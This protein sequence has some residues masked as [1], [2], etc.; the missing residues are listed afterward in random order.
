MAK[1]RATKKVVKND[2]SKYLLAI[3]AIVAVVGIVLMV[4]DRSSG[5]SE[6]LT[7]GIVDTADDVETDLI[8]EAWANTRAGSCFDSD[9]NNYITKGF[10]FS[11]THNQVKVDECLNNTHVL[12]SI[13]KK[14]DASVTYTSKDCSKIR[15]YNT[16]ICKNG[17][18]Y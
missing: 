5:V 16:T 1:K 14:T 3:V 11:K 15:N 10:A 4:N 2:Y 18:C 17:A 9:D 13:C 6:T 8:G 7:E 12:E